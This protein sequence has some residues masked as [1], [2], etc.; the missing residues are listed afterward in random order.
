PF[1]RGYAWRHRRPAAALVL[2]HGLQSHAQWFAEAGEALL[3]RGVAVYA[4]DRR[5]SGSS[6]AVRGDV[7]RYADWYGELDS[8]VRL[9]RA[10]YPAAPVHLVGHCFGANVAL[11]YALTGSAGAAAVRSIVMLTPGLY[12]R[13]DYSPAQKLRI[14]AAGLLAPG[15][16]FPVPQE[17][18]LFTR[19]SEVL[20]W[21]GADSGGARTLTARCLLQINRMVKDLRRRAGELTVPVL[22]L[23]AARDRLSHNSR[24]RALLSRALGDRCSWREFD[25]EHF[26][27]AEPCRD[28]V[29]Q[30]LVGWVAEQTE[31]T[32]RAE[33]KEDRQ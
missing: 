31:R 17:D 27:L 32:E 19:D 11:G 29:V 7:E 3:E 5:G 8:V 25:A 12:V 13:P 20:A 10:E 9:A 23:E 14:L 22:V 26:L 2:V 16:W 33:R 18:D 21:I 28:D 30:T 6:R 24:N 1:V 15:A 4:V